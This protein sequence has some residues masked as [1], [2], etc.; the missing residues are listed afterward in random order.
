MP[1]DARTVESEEVSVVRSAS[2][3][4][5]V[6][7]RELL[8]AKCGLYLGEERDADLERALDAV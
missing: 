1:V 6:R 2:G 5:V 3:D 8:Y 7:L 4:D